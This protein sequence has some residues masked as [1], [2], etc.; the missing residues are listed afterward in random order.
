MFVV[1]RRFF[2]PILLA[3]LFFLGVYVRAEGKIDFNRQIRPIL[4]DTCF[5]CHGPDEQQRK[6]RLR[7]DQFSGATAKL[8]KQ[9][10]AIVPGKPDESELLRRIL[11]DDPTERMP[12][13]RTRKQ[14]TP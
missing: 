2:S 4:S 14:V 9:G 6:A 3:A 5:A 13:E 1:G 12:P 7:L 11:T 8:R 10:H